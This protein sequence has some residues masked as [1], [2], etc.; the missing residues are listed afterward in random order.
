MKFAHRILQD[1]HFSSKIMQRM[2]LG[3]EFHYIL[4]SSTW[5]TIKKLYKTLD[6]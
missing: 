3:A 5:H 2:S 1:K 4:I 6:Y